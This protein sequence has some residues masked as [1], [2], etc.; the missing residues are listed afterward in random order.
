MKTTRFAFVALVVV[1][2][3]V[4]AGCNVS[5]EYVDADAATFAAVSPE[6]LEYIKADAKLTQEQKDRRNRTV[7]S[8]KIRLE[9][10]K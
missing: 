5:K 1:L 9:R 7:E 4:L 8:W 2:A 3:F 10:A 6:Y